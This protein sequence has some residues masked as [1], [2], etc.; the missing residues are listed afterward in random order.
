MGLS[1][2]LACGAASPLAYFYPVY[3]AV[4]LVHRALRDDHFCATKYGADWEAYKRRVPF[5]FVPG[6]L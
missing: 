3:F 2:S 4:L 1:W 5:V 6:I